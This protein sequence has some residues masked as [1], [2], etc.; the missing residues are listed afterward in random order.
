VVDYDRSAALVVVDVQNDFAD[1]KGSLYAVHR[2][3]RRPATRSRWPRPA[4]APSIVPTSVTRR[5]GPRRQARELLPSAA[6]AAGAAVR[7]P[8]QVTTVGAA[9]ASPMA[10]MVRVR[11]VA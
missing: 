11:K 10:R 6:A 4:T 1:P 9:V 2:P 7:R 3:A 8:A 5:H